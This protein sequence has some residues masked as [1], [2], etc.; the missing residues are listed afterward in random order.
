MKEG[1]IRLLVST[2]NR[3]RNIRRIYNISSGYCGVITAVSSVSRNRIATV[4]YCR[5]I[6]TS[7][8][9]TNKDTTSTADKIGNAG[10]T[11]KGNNIK[12]PVLASFRSSSALMC[13]FIDELSLFFP[14]SSMDV[15]STLS[16]TSSF[17]N[18]NNIILVRPSIHRSQNAAL[19]IA[20]DAYNRLNQHIITST[21]IS[22][23]DLCKM[24]FSLGK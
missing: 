7:S 9:S 22:V 23:S 21:R 3:C 15:A 20:G 18:D 13:K 12:H 19:N 16:P 14:G 17:N 11:N 4:R 24:S 1:A 6:S 10:V 2:Y 5:G 8:I